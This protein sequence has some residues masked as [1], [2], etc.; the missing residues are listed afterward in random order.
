MPDIDHG[1]V[2]LADLKGRN[3]A[4]AYEVASILR[5][6]VRTVRTAIINGDIPATKAGSTYRVPVAWLRQQ[7]AG[8]P[9]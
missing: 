7:A 9:A 8:V 4:F 1:P 3:F 6:D 5:M 2:T